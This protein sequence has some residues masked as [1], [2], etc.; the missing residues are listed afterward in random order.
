MGFLFRKTVC[1]WPFYCG[2]LSTILLRGFQKDWSRCSIPGG[3]CSIPGSYRKYYFGRIGFLFREAGFLFREPFR[4]VGVLF[5]EP[6]RRVGVLFREAGVLFRDP[7]RRLGV[8]FRDPFRRVGVLF[9][10]A[11]RRV[12][13][14]F[15]KAGVGVLSGK[16]L[17]FCKFYSEWVPEEVI[18]SGKL[19][20]FEHLQLSFY[21]THVFLL[22]C[23]E[24]VRKCFILY[25][26]LFFSFMSHVLD[27]CCTDN[28]EKTNCRIVVKRGKS[29]YRV[30]A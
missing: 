10:E 14:L 24:F 30:L 20:M 7:F 17:V 8:L 28:G 13:F 12:F 1:R 29:M 19:F 21:F 15:R 3:W 26:P 4:R 6:V 18:C 22:I 23:Y 25:R 27:C 2:K 16:L 5:R 9:R 11:V